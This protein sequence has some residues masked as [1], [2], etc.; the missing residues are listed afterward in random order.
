MAHESYTGTVLETALAIIEEKGKA[1]CGDVAS[2][3]FVQT[4]VD[5]KKV[6]NALSDLKKSGRLG[7]IERGVYGKPAAAGKVIE[8]REVMWRLLRMRRQLSVDDLV[9]LAG[10]SRDYAQEWLQML[11]GR[12]IVK[13]LNN[14][15]W[16]LVDTTADMP[17]DTVKAGRLRQI[18][19]RKKDALKM[20]SAIDKGLTALR[21][22]IEE[23]E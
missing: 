4:R 17:D 22:I 12:E 10:V 7:H 15:T 1:T 8:K 14:G 13:V 19:L 6:L 2:A 11:A 21:N 18:R 20:L 5:N 23:V 9:E 16:L 3:L